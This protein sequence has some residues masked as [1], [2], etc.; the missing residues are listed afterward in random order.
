[1]TLA[2]TFEDQ[3]GLLAWAAPRLDLPR[4]PDGAKGLGVYEAETGD[5]RAVMVMV[6]TY[7]TSCDLHFA[8]DG[9]RRW[10]TRNILGG[11]FGYVFVLRGVPQV[12]ITVEPDNVPALVMNLKLGFQIEARMRGIMSD[13]GDAIVMSMRATDCPWI[14]DKEID[15]G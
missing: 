14:K 11:L 15:H 1:M 13:G 4:W 2:L 5:I 6:Q 10:A 9:S 8:T 7:S 3:E 12:N